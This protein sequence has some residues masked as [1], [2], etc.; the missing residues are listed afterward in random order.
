MGRED[1]QEGGW[2]GKMLRRAA[3]DFST[4]CRRR[5]LKGSPLPRHRRALPAGASSRRDDFTW[6]VGDPLTTIP[7]SQMSKFIPLPALESRAL[8]SK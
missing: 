2:A 8:E 6:T 5:L 3:V 1:A 4:G 7:S